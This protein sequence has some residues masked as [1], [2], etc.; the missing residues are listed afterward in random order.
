MLLVI[1]PNL[2]LDRILEVDTFQPARVQRSRSVTIQPGGKGSNVARVF[3]QL[4]GDVV[5]AGFVGRSDGEAVAVPLRRMGVRIEAVGAFDG[6]SR[7]C[8]II[9]DRQ[10]NVHPTV[11]NEE[12]RQIEKD[13]PAELIAVIDK[14]LPRAKAI[15]TTGSLSRGLPETF[16]RAVLHRAATRNIITAVDAAGAVLR[17]ALAAR[18]TFAKPNRDEFFDLL[19]SSRLSFMATHMAITLGE[20][21]AV[22]IHDGRLLQAV[23]PRIERTN[24]VGAGDAFAA[25]YLKALL[26]GLDV[27]GALRWATAAAVADAGTLQPGFVDAAYVRELLKEV[28]VQCT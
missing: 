8:T 7:N 19:A 14:W 13:A 4:G 28:V 16:Y 17:Q 20:D 10:S 12:S 11:I 26:D 9:C 25:G 22:L 24:P 6:Y 1:C 23:P 15:L 27:Q 3:A 2:G 18:P 21:G 5:L